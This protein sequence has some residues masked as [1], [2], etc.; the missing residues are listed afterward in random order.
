MASKPRG[1]KHTAH[2]QHWPAPVWS[3]AAAVLIR[4]HALHTHPPRPESKPYIKIVGPEAAQ[5][6]AYCSYTALPSLRDRGSAAAWGPVKKFWGD[7]S[8]PQAAITRHFTFGP[9]QHGSMISGRQNQAPLL[10]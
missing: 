1:K 7:R 6:G 4:G 2:T 5:Q 9:A 3:T 8:I 10:D